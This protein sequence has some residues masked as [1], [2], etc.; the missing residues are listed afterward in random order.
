MRSI[1]MVGS[2]WDEKE[3]DV[4]F[5]EL[6]NTFYVAQDP[7]QPYQCMKNLLLSNGLPFNEMCYSA[8]V[9]LLS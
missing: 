6:I 9:G 7:S 3:A 2:C 4:F 5:V 1:W 8:C